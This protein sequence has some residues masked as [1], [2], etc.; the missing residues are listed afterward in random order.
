MKHVQYE[1]TFISHYHYSI[2]LVAQ[3]TNCLLASIYLKSMCKACY[4]FDLSNRLAASGLM[5]K[6]NVITSCTGGRGFNKSKFCSWQCKEKHVAMVKS[7][8]II[9]CDNCSEATVDE[10]LFCSTCWKLDLKICQYCNKKRTERGAKCRTCV[11][12]KMTKIGTPTWFTK[13]LKKMMLK[14]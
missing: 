4:D 13:K 1:I 6:M 2:L 10:R 8:S 3:C 11:G 5:C 14:K 7:G 12:K 9:W